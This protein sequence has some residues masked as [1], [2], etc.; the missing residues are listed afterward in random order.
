MVGI[1]RFM[2]AR[3][4]KALKKEYPRFAKYKA[5]LSWVFF[6]LGECGFLYIVMVIAA[7]NRDSDP[8]IVNTW[9]YTFF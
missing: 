5:P 6:T 3:P 2:K 8:L 9:V 4:S 1:L 7:A